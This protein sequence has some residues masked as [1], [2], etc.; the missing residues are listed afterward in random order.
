MLYEDT[1]PQTEEKTEEH[2]MGKK[3]G[4]EQ[5]SSVNEENNA[6]KEL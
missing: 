4:A 6:S 2:E 1:L 3:R 5:N